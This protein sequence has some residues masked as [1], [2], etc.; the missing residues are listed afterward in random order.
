VEESP[1][2][3]SWDWDAHQDAV[4]LYY[5][6]VR[7]IQG[8]ANCTIAGD[9]D[10]NR[11]STF[12]EMRFAVTLIQRRLQNL[13]IILPGVELQC[14]KMFAEPSCLMQIGTLQVRFLPP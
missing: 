7:D 4:K 10:A 12:K 9:W 5:E 11:K 14:M 1:F 6:I 8:I 3:V 13:A 2:G